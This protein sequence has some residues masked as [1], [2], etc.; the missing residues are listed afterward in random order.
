MFFDADI[1]GWTTGVL[2]FT[3]AQLLL[4]SPEQLLRP[5]TALLRL[6]GVHVLHIN[7]DA[8]HHSEIKWV[9]AYLGTHAWCYSRKLLRLENTDLRAYAH[10]M[11]HA[12]TAANTAV[13]LRVGRR[14]LRGSL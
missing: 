11:L 8:K 12:P 6:A 9:Q 13:V 5:L 7:N 10:R 3:L 2:A 4:T 14:P 1:S